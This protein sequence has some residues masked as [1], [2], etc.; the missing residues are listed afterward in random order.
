MRKKIKTLSEL[1]LK[2]LPKAW[3]REAMA[4]KTLRKG[5]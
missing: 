4:R 2:F 5:S 3:I 1:K